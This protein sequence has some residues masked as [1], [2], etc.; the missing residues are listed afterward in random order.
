MDNLENAQKQLAIVL[1]KKHTL[2]SEYN[3]EENLHMFAKGIED[4][5]VSIYSQQVA[6]LKSLA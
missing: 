4:N 3:E 2:T 6:Y 1:T 5:K